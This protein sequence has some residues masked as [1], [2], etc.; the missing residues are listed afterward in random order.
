MLV[1]Q[2]STFYFMLV[3][4]QIVQTVAC[5]ISIVTNVINNCSKRG[6]YYKMLPS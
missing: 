5:T 4:L 2:D 1:K 3:P 6:L